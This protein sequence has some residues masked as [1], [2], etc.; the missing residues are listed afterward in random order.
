MVGLVFGAWQ[1][2]RSSKSTATATNTVQ[3]VEVARELLKTLPNGT[4]YDTVLTK[5]MADHQAEAGVTAQI[6]DILGNSTDNA[7]AKDTVKKL[8]ETLAAL[9]SQAPKV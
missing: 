4:A 9:Q 2:L 6:L 8:Q 1:W 5:W 3:V 7:T